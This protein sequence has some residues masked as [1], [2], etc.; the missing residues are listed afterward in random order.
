MM[1]FAELPVSFWGHALESACYILNRGSSKSIVKTPYEIWTGRKPTLSHLRVWGCL[2]YIKH[3]QSD[4][5]GPKSDR[6]LFVGYPKESKGYYFYLSKE[7]RLF[8]VLRATFL[9]KEFLREGTEASKVEL[10]EVQQIEEPTHSW[11]ATKSAL[12][13]SNTESIEDPIRRS[14]RVPR[15]PDRYYAFFVRDDDP[16]E[17]D[18]NNEDMIT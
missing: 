3:L 12:I 9:K 2:A 15:Q 8:I 1:G 4:K 17:L 11:T 14:G 6:R 13:R 18:E 7:Q 5:L 10:R 16:I